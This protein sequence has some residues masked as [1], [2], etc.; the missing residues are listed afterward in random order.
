RSG[1][2]RPEVLPNGRTQIVTIL[3]AVRSTGARRPGKGDGT[4]AGSGE[5]LENRGRRLLRQRAGGDDMQNRRSGFGSNR[6]G[7][8]D[9]L[10]SDEKGQGGKGRA[11]FPF[12]NCQRSAMEDQRMITVERDGY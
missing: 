11:D 3:H 1:D 12:R 10:W 8:G 6:R 2:F 4:A 5:R 7:E 9:V